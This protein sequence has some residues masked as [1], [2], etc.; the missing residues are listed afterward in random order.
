MVVLRT[1]YC[2]SEFPFRFFAFLWVDVCRSCTLACRKHG[3]PFSSSSWVQGC[4]DLARLVR[5][6]SLRV[7][8]AGDLHPNGHTS[9]PPSRNRFSPRGQYL[10]SLDPPSAQK[11]LLHPQPSRP[12]RPSCP[13]KMFRLLRVRAWLCPGSQGDVTT[14]RLLVVIS[15]LGEAE[16]CRAL[17]EPR[18]E[19]EM[20]DSRWCGGQGWWA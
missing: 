3:F 12:A 16:M 20:D 1:S 13:A 4:S 8:A 18:Q 19:A 17:R 2:A 11:H 14:L 7:P 10:R 9:T 6:C 15:A 5:I